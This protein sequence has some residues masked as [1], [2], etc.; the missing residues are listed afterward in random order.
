MSNATDQVGSQGIDLLIRSA[1]VIDPRDGSRGVY[2]DVM[3]SGDR[4]I[5][6]ASSTGDDSPHAARVVDAAGM[7]LVPGFSDMHAHPLVMKDPAA[8][9]ELMLA[10]GITGFRQMSGSAALLHDRERGS[11]AQ[12]V[13]PRLLA[14]PGSILTPLNAGTG[15]DAV[16]TVR[17]QKE[18]GAD[19]IKA[20][21]VSADVFYEAQAEALRL[22]I[23]ILGHL[24]SDIDV[25]RAS[26]EGMRSIEHLGPGVGL[27]ACCSSAHDDL[28]AKIQTMPPRKLPSTKLPFMETIFEHV[29]KRIVINPI[30]MAKQ[31]DVDVLDEACSTYDQDAAL[32]LAERLAAN[33]TWQV[34]T[35]IRSRTNYIC[36]DAAFRSDPDLRY[37]SPSTV[38]GWSKATKK[39]T[40]FPNASR[41]TFRLAYAT[42]LHLVKLLDDSGVRMLAGSDVC[43]AAW[44][45]PGPALHKEFDELGRAGFS[46]LRV[47]QMTTSDAADFLGSSA[48]LGSVS[49]GKYA[50]LVLLEGDPL[51]SIDNLH[52]VAGV[53]RDGRYYDRGHLDSIKET[54]ALKRSVR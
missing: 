52:K 7:Y 50:D 11:V 25:Y 23:P 3:I 49:Q 31:G 15:P 29:L 42:L 10:F 9:L 22:D 8:N 40:R 34:P 27:L 6:V 53:V 14:M 19:F 38:K 12:G 17:E 18:L 35:L 36:D 26:G 33:G 21:L 39:F 5:R 37:V 45:V 28:H 20:G 41:E 16:A 1:T 4:I 13:A 54:I 46:P 30:N 24:P 51:E 44:E 32:A 48:D 47:L 43:G 2:Q